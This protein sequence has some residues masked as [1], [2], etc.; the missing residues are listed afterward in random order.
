MVTVST[1]TG[2]VREFRTRGYT[3]TRHRGVAGFHGV[4]KPKLV[5][6]NFY[7]YIH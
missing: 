4:S 5:F 1:G 3:V 7:Y 2:A 6:A